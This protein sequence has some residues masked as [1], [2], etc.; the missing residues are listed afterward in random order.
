MFINDQLTLPFLISLH[1]SLHLSKKYALLSVYFFSYAK[2]TM[3]FIN[4]ILPA[5]MMLT[6]SLPINSTAQN[7][8]DAIIGKW[9]S[10]ENNLAVE[11]YKQKNDFRARV[12]WFDDSDDKSKP[13]NTRLDEKNHDKVLRRRKIIGMEALRNLQYSKN[14][15]EWQ[16][17]IIYDSSSGKEWD[18]KAWINEDGLL[19]VR[20]YW[21][22][23]IFGQNITFKKII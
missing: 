20:G 1:L 21:H 23:A 14:D 2:N 18:A 22:F 4:I 15:D 12:I 10:S 17:G 7:R 9:M 6:C 8:E 3:K 5:I 13:M 19:K 11:V 16:H